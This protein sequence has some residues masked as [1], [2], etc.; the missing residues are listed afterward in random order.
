MNRIRISTA[1][2]RLRTLI[3]KGE[4]FVITVHGRQIAIVTPTI[5]TIPNPKDPK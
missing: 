3:D 5:V 4:P 2:D 1:R